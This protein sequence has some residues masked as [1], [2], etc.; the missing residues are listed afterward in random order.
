MCSLSLHLELI[1]VCQNQ[2]RSPTQI[3]FDVIILVGLFAR[4][5]VLGFDAFLQTLKKY[6]ASYCKVY[7]PVGPSHVLDVPRATLGG[8]ILRALIVKFTFPSAPQMYW[9]C[10]EQPLEQ[11]PY[12]SY[13]K[14]TFPSA[15]LTYWMCL[16][17]PLEQGSYA[18]YCKVYLPVGPADVL[19]VP[20][21]TL[22]AGILHVLL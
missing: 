18:S 4:S 3:A 9:M 1:T 6:Y 19:D 7:L 20:G 14:V 11:G 16:E 15:P 21:A 10:L 22:G 8:G 12:A 13:C 5:F 2:E 17:Q